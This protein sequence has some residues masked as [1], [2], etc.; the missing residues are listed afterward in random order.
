[1]IPRQSPSSERPTMIMV[2]ECAKPIRAHP[3]MT[4]SP[5]QIRVFLAP[6]SLT[7]KLHR[8]DPNSAAKAIELPIH[9][10]ISL[11]STVSLGTEFGLVMLVNAHPL[12]PVGTQIE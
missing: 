4:G 2:N 9:D 6:N 12:Q 7:I 11:S 5:T 1:M 10:L 8:T 3:T